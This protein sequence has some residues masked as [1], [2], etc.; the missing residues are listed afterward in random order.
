MR[1]SKRARKRLLVALALLVLI[2]GGVIG[3]RVF[4]DAQAVR[5]TESKR[6][7]GM[8]AYRDGQYDA[9]LHDLSYAVSRRR[10]DIELL[11]AFADTRSK[12]P[13]AN[14]AHLAEAA[15]IYDNVL[16]LEPLHPVALRRLLDLYLHPSVARPADAAVI[17]RRM[18]EI[19][20]D[21]VDAVAT[22]ARY[23]FWQRNFAAAMPAI[24]TLQRLEPQRME[25]R[26]FELALL[27]AQSMPDGEIIARCDRW[28]E[29][30]PESE[31]SFHY[32]RAS[33][34][35]MLG[36]L[37][38][39]AVAANLAAERGARTPELLRQLIQLLDELGETDRVGALLEQ[40][41]MDFPHDA[42]VWEE[43][44]RR[45]WL[46]R[47]LE[48]AETELDLAERAL[49]TSHPDLLRWRVLLLTLRARGDEAEPLL[50]T[51]EEHA[52]DLAIAERDARRA[53]IGAIRAHAQLGSARWADAQR[54]FK[55]AIA[56][57]PRN[58]I[59]HYLQGEAYRGI[60][61]FELAAAS[62]ERAAA[63]DPQW[64]VPAVAYTETLLELGRPVAALDSCVRLQYGRQSI[65]PAASVMFLRA[66]LAAAQASGGADSPTM[67]TG[68]SLGQITAVLAAELAAQGLDAGAALHA[69]YFDALA[70]ARDRGTLER[71][72]AGNLASDDVPADVLLV[73]AR[74]AS[75]ADLSFVEALLDRAERIGAD[76]IDLAEVRAVHALRIGTVAEGLAAI[77]RARLMA[78]ASPEAS[79][80]ADRLRA[81][82]LSAMGH[83]AAPD[84]L[85]ALLDR[86][87]ENAAVAAFVLAQDV[88]WLEPD[89][90]RA[91]IDRRR[92]HIGGGGDGSGVTDGDAS[93]GEST[94]LMLAEAMFILQ[95][96][97]AN[98]QQRARALTMVSDV[99]RQTPDS[100]A[101]LLLMADALA[102]GPQADRRAAIEQMERALQLYPSR[103]D[104]YPKIISLYQ[105]VGDFRA[106]ATYLDR[107]DR[108]VAD[109]ESEAHLEARLRERQGDIE[110]ALAR[111]ASH[112][113]AGSPVT[114]QLALASLMIRTGRH[115]EARVVLDELLQ[116]EPVDDR[117]VSLAADLLAIRGRTGEALQLFER[118]P[119]IG[120]PA[121]DA[122]RLADF[123]ER[124]GGF[125]EALALRRRVIVLDA[126]HV[127]GHEALAATLLLAG[128]AA[129]ARQAAEDGLGR[130]PNHPGLRVS[131]A[132][133]SIEASAEERARALALVREL[134][135]F[136]A[137]LVAVLETL[138]RINMAAPKP[139]DL[140]AAS[141]LARTHGGFLPA[142][143]LAVNVHAAAG[144]IDRAID[145][146][147][148]AI[149]R[150]PNE[151]KPADWA[152]QL[153][154]TQSRFEEALDVARIWRRRALDDPYQVDFVVAAILLHLDRAREA[155]EAIAPH[156]DRAAAE[157][158]KGEGHI[159]VVINALVA[160]DR[161][162]EA[163]AFWRGFVD[164]DR[165]WVRMW[166]D[167]ADD[168]DPAPGRRMLA[169]A[170]EF[171]IDDSAGMLLA[172]TAWARQHRATGDVMDAERADALA[173]AAARDPATA[174]DAAL[175]RGSIAEGLGES[176]V[177][178]A[179]YRAALR[180]RP[181]AAVA[182]NNLAFLL[183]AREGDLA[184]AD[185]LSARA[186]GLE[187]NI[188][189][190]H[191]T[192]AVV[193][194]RRNR[195]ADAE[196]AARQAVAIEP[197]RPSY[198][199][200]L[201]AALA[202]RDRFADAIASLDRAEALL[203][204][205]ANADKTLAD[206]IESLRRQV[207]EAL[208][209]S[210]AGRQGSD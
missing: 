186:V 111:L 2:I 85:R 46:L 104:L 160:A 56:L 75:L 54:A 193:L 130:H 140:G 62:Y 197:A 17:A 163:Q 93:A 26:R 21:D 185:A 27:L 14:D 159:R 109:S 119:S 155:A 20:A 31:G 170:E 105:E 200:T 103:Y 206:R 99:L 192:R 40:A 166:L 171:L 168:V 141:A 189:A 112:V 142:Y 174:A 35:A 30:N 61:E 173:A 137:D 70:I 198:H 150:H 139:G 135:P 207:D 97:S 128:D 94:R 29:E 59:L 44:V 131:L 8:A 152:V 127:E 110:G 113:G 47:D 80:R 66:W 148:E 146:C 60:E 43:A 57:D 154:L 182:L 121:A 63:C 82:Y 49:G 51:L 175:L 181:D 190:F 38:E 134:G 194:L 3:L 33:A 123:H 11:L 89:L 23:E 22:V 210:S 187:P 52:A 6:E 42:W 145:L 191:D 68:V 205:A 156:L 122:T 172:A 15:V 106:A 79:L 164:E 157:R 84:A 25:W 92:A 41:K 129:A 165:A 34:L 144:Q 124:H 65:P 116:V 98:D 32:L 176:D 9:A 18:L 81:W 203:R 90:V 87:P 143:Q 196:A 162:D 64:L 83:P 115:D 202:S 86:H 76:P 180:E 161:F 100:L 177:A 10:D 107:L 153:L 184:E 5:L 4:R 199:V 117:A 183:S 55:G 72:I 126:D 195:A 12:L 201:A 133:A 71:Y 132:L 138:D 19:E 91:A 147:R 125:E 50:A 48:A 167:L 169:A 88:A 158:N 108:N 16:R 118:H 37:D 45:P 149:G 53:W 69:L 28:I 179:H 39:A 178:I 136:H 77:E 73:A 74:A 96:E 24:V 209:L 1:L 114:E 208:T 78:D 58:A 7:A 188:A 102:S 13:T 120:G 204:N 95:F 151:W 101:G 36:R 67:S